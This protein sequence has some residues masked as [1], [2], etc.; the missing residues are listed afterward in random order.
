MYGSVIRGDLALI[1]VGA[2]TVIGDNCTLTAGAV[3]SELSPS[4]AISAG[5]SVDPELFVGDYT[6]VG[7]NC[8]LTS[9]HLDGMNIIGAGSTIGPG[10]SIGRGSRL[11]PNSVVEPDTEVPDAELWG[12]NPAQKIADISPKDIAIAERE[13]ELRTANTV[14]HAYEFL[15][16]GFGYLEKERSRQERLAA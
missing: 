6:F 16:H 7:P 1:H 13:A 5:L 15:P 14:A 2:V 4:D 10:A 3:D 11:E 9:C 8:S 12:G